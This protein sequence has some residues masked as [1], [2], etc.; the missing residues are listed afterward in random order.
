M[1]VLYNKGNL[2]WISTD[3]N[4][5]SFNER[6]YLILRNFQRRIEQQKRSMYL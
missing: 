1:I 2:D 4:F 3:D 6:T 5:G